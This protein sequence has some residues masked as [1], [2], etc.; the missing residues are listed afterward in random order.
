MAVPEGQLSEPLRNYWGST[1]VCGT[2]GKCC[3]QFNTRDHSAKDGVR[4]A[5]VTRPEGSPK[6]CVKGV[7]VGPRSEGHVASCKE[8]E[9]RDVVHIAGGAEA[10]ER[11]AR[12]LM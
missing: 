3:Q 7:R 11:R 8:A 4:H 5:K 2:A 12:R 6:R 10:L 1:E 9:A